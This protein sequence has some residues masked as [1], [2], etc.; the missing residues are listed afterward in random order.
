M[1]PDGNIQE[2]SD[3]IRS[4]AEEISRQ[5]HCLY[6]VNFI[7]SGI[8]FCDDDRNQLAYQAELLPTANITSED[9]RSL[10][11]RWVHTQP[12][13]L[14]NSQIY[15]LDSSCPVVVITFGKTTCEYYESTTESESESST[16]MIASSQS[17]SVY[18]L[19]SIINP[20]RMRSEGYS[21]LFVCLCVCLSML[22]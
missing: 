7:T 1:Q 12:S 17:P 2:M 13:I 16:V 15:E 9:A 22:C 10:T 6:S 20:R 3:I 19:A 21:S 8:L 14:I 11:Q 4:V 18:E 5:C